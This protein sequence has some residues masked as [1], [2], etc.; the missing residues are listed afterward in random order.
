[1]WLAP[2]LACKVHLQRRVDAHRFPLRYT[3]TAYDTFTD[4]ANT[5][6][7]KV[8]LRGASGDGRAAD[9]AQRMVVA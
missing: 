8:V 5:N 1:M 2:S 9:A 3:M 4:A 6:D 7:L